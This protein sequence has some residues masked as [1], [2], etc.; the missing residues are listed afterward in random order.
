[1]SISGN[2]KKCPKI[3]H[4]VI[5]PGLLS[6]PFPTSLGHAFQYGARHFLYLAVIVSMVPS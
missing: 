3:K 5:V 1:M 4:M 6:L 2:S